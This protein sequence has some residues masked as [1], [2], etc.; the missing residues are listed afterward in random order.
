M[1]GLEKQVIK[2]CESEHGKRDILRKM[3][4]Q[5][6]FGPDAWR[7]SGLLGLYIVVGEEWLR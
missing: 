7:V 3:R 5:V 1:I 2:E 4:H 6:S